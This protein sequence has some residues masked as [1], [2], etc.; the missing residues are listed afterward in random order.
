MFKKDWGDFSG[1]YGSLSY[2]IEKGSK[3]YEK[4]RL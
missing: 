2:I 3:G 4:G 1:F